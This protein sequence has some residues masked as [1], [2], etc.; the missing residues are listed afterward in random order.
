MRFS[1]GNVYPRAARAAA[2]QTG[3]RPRCI[4][5]AIATSVSI[6]GARRRSGRAVTYRLSASRDMPERRSRSEYERQGETGSANR[7]SMSAPSALLRWE[8]VVRSPRGTATAA[9]GAGGGCVSSPYGVVT[10]AGPG[11]S[12]CATSEACGTAG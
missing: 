3:S 2:R 6:V 12:A 7:R 10:S 1:S 4:A 9:S 8:R 11:A 5:P